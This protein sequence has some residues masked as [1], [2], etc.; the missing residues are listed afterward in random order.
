MAEFPPAFTPIPCKPLFFDLAREQ[1][2]FPSLEDKVASPKQ[3]GGQGQGGS[4][5]WLGG[6]LGGWGGQQQKK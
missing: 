6:W 2:A 4:G 1:L 5:G 3:G